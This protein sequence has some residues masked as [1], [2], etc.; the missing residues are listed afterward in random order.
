MS[1][2][3]FRCVKNLSFLVDKF[4]VD[5]KN[6]ERLMDVLSHYRLGYVRLKDYNNSWFFPRTP[7]LPKTHAQKLVPILNNLRS[8]LAMVRMKV[9]E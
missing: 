4:K 5:L 2:P 8:N 7:K 1:S 3:A 9:I 6:W